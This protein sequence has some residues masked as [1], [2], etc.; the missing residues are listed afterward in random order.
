MSDGVAGIRR[1]RLLTVAFDRK[2]GHFG[3]K[4]NRPGN[5]VNFQGTF[6]GIPRFAVFS[7]GVPYQEERNPIAFVGLL[8][9][10]NPVMPICLSCKWRASWQFFSESRE[11]RPFM[12]TLIIGTSS[13]RNLLRLQRRILQ[14]SWKRDL[15]KEEGEQLKSVRI[16]RGTWERGCYRCWTFGWFYIGYLFE[17]IVTAEWSSRAGWGATLREELQWKVDNQW[18][19]SPASFITAIV[20]W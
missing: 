1:A 4:L 15:K 11:L 9:L 19:K 20:K 16:P 7:F 18:K 12:S 5:F 2:L 17:P 8:I 13:S 14:K 3:W 10:G 6:R